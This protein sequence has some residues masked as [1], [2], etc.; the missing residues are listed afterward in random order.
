MKR[1]YI[2]IALA[3]LALGL[4]CTMMMDDPSSAENGDED[5]FTFTIDYGDYGIVYQEN[6]TGMVHA[7]GYTG[8]PVNV[9]IPGEVE[10]GGT[11]YM[12][13]CMKGTFIGCKTLETFRGGYGGDWFD[14]DMFTFYECTALRTI[15]FGP[16]LRYIHDFALLECPS[17]ESYIMP[18]GTTWDTFFV[19]D[20]VL[21]I[22]PNIMVEGIAIFKYP[23]NRSATEYQV[24]DYVKIILTRAF[25]YAFNLEK[26]FIHKD[27]DRIDMGAFHECVAL[28]AFEVDVKNPNYE[29]LDGVLY[30]RGLEKLLSYPAGITAKVFDMPDSV[31]D[32]MDQAFFGSVYLEDVKFSSNLESVGFEAFN[33]SKSLKRVVLPEGTELIGENCFTLSTELEYVSFPS[34]MLVFEKYLFRGCT[35]LTTVYNASDVPLNSLHFVESTRTFTYYKDA[36][37]T[38]VHENPD[39]MYGDIH[40]LQGLPKD[41][42]NHIVFISAG[43][44]AAVVL[45]VLIFVRF[46][47]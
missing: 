46:K 45:S 14:I 26:V 29:V 39:E 7:I 38:T 44:A 16:V 28:K 2:L 10:Y 4:S 1:T 36:A 6:A 33:K 20:G 17:L 22:N 30:H 34:T 13:G 12:V 41:S 40:L 32:V 37:H 3:I 21:M 35:D 19:D 31:T 18:E 43:I 23:A 24:P 5:I 8:T 15:E 27:V 42:E 25:D 11:K 47:N 9:D